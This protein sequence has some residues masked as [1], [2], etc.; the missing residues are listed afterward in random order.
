MLGQTFVVRQRVLNRGIP[1]RYGRSPPLPPR[2][3]HPFRKVHVGDG[4]LDP[5]LVETFIEPKVYERAGV[6]RT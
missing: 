4:L 5:N 2:D 3:A 1:C 6:L